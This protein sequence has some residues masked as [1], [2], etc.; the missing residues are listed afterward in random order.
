MKRV[1]VT[2]CPGSGKSVFARRLHEKTGLPLYHLDNIWWKPDRTHV[3]REE[4]DAALAGI[5]ERDEWI[6]DG[7]YSRTFEPRIRACDTVILLDCD[8]DVC[9]Q[10]IMERVGQTRP[11]MPWTE[12]TLDPELVELVKTYRERNNPVLSELFRRYPDREIRVFRDR[13]EAQRW[14]D[15][16]KTE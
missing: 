2:G 6:I 1:M 7:S 13:T 4:F 5:L 3:T 9:L 14:L 15:E 11:D 16:L 12:Q 8:T 10:G